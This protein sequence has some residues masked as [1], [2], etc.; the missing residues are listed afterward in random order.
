MEWGAVAHVFQLPVV[1]NGGNHWYL[2]Q[3]SGTLSPCASMLQANTL[4]FGFYKLGSELLVQPA[5]KWR[6]SYFG[7]N[8]V[9]Q[10]RLL[11]DMPWSEMTFCILK[12]VTLVKQ[13]GLRG[14]WATHQSAVGLC[15]FQLD[16]VFQLQVIND[17]INKLLRNFRN[18]D[19]C[20]V[21]S[22]EKSAS[23][24]YLEVPVVISAENGT[25]LPT[26]G[27]FHIFQGSWT[28]GS[29]TMSMSVWQEKHYGAKI[30]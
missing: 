26:E 3:F 12:L 4:N 6:S 16:D 7:R 15:L 5:P 30:W 27:L 8:P 25:L 22:R 1:W 19:N 14:A 11:S 17:R 23:S 20:K 28:A 21:V 29:C 10:I 18:I 24:V 2:G 13:V 9:G